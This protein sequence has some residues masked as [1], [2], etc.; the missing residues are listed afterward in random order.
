MIIGAI[1]AIIFGGILFGALSFAG[2]R[3]GSRMRTIIMGG[4][5]LR[6]FLQFFM[7][8]IPFF[9]HGAGGDCH[10][11]EDWARAIARI[12]S[13]FGV[14]FVSSRELEVL[15]PTS[16]PPN[17]F[18]LMI[19]FNGGDATRLGCTAL[20][21]LA[22]GLTALNIYS[23]ALEFGAERKNAIL[24]ASILYLQ[25]AFLFYTSDMYKDGFVLCFTLGSLASALR[26]SSKFT[27][28]HAAI[29]IA[30]VIALWYVRFY[31]IFVTIAPLLVG[32]ANF[33]SKDARRPLVAAV[34]LGTAGLLLGA[35]TDILQ[36]A[37]DRASDTYVHATATNVLEANQTG[38][39]GIAFDDGGNPTGALPAKLAYTLLAP[40]PW[41]GGSLGF[42]LGKLD[43]FLWYFVLYRA[44]RAAWRADRRVVLMLGTFVVPCTVM[45]AMSV[46]NV[47]L[48]VRQRLVIVAATAVLAAMYTPQ[49]QK[50]TSR[51][52]LRRPKRVARASATRAAT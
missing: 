41:A 47:G 28:L 27:F 8:E 49:K 45:Y 48:I 42:Q 46:S 23:L 7:R 19:Y 5:A 10:L 26:L 18:A 50:V 11:Y 29:G 22:A 20:V 4:Y 51:S 44:M 39:S 17:L 30:C 14:H 15:G 31:L 38:G 35:F 16:L 34:L 13:Q 3:K 43:V 37:S 21:A 32:I 12:W 2:E 6:L 25:P 24:F 9:T 36:I 1:L 52:P 40:F 33:G